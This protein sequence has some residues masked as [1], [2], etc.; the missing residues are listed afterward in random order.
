MSSDGLRA[1]RTEAVRAPVDQTATGDCRPLVVKRK[2]QCKRKPP[3]PKTM[4]RLPDLEVGKSAVINGLSCLDAQHGYW[5]AIDELNCPEPRS[6]PRLRRP[7]PLSG[8]RGGW[9]EQPL[10]R[11]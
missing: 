8:A 9:P 4:L 7:A 6:T 3:T 1:T 2:L 5:H 11:Q 10:E